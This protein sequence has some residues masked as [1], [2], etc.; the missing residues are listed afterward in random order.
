MR[1]GTLRNFWRRLRRS[2][3]DE[4]RDLDFVAE[5]EEYLALL[6]EDIAGNA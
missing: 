2:V 6:A 5:I 3:R 1:V 4:P